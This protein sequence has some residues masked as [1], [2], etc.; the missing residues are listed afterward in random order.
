LSGIKR[1][2]SSCAP[3]PGTQRYRHSCAP[4][5]GTE[6]CRRSCRSLPFLCALSLHETAPLLLRALVR[7]EISSPLLPLLA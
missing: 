3:S 7:H 5:S 1:G 6:L 2:H 4:L